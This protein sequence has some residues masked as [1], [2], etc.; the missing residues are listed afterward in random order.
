M[1]QINIEF[2]S[3]KDA[4]SPHKMNRTLHAC[5]KNECYFSFIIHFVVALMVSFYLE[6]IHVLVFTRCTQ[7]I[8]WFGL[9]WYR[10]FLIIISHQFNEIIQKLHFA[11]S[12]IKIMKKVP[13]QKNILLFD[14]Q[15]IQMNLYSSCNS[16][17]STDAGVCNVF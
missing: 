9:L 3:L 7:A 1:T 14:F 2:L 16:S 15:I 17:S 13:T 4:S 6:M 11:C 5:G 12:Q 10:Y 8:N